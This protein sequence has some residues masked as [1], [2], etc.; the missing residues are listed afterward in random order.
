MTGLTQSVRDG[1]T[2]HPGR[3]TTLVVGGGRPGLALAVELA[4]G[5]RSVTFVGEDAS[6]DADEAIQVL[7]RRVSDAGSL[8]DV[9]AVVDDVAAVIAVGT[10]SETL[11][12]AHLARLELDD[13]P[14]V[15]L[16]DDPWRQS[17]FD[18]IE[19]KALSTSAL[20]ADAVRDRLR[21]T[22]Q[23]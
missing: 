6:D 9:L 20:L 23:A 18:G 13:V 2:E 3:A 17:A 15:A 7:P 5:D 16:V 8:R 10:D 14:I 1:E 4:E 12:V 19:V 11:L 22:A 21:R